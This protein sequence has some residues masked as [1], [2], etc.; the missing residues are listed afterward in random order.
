[1]TLEATKKQVANMNALTWTARMLLSTVTDADVAVAMDAEKGFVCKS[2][3][4]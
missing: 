2:R 4:E 1:M 3:N